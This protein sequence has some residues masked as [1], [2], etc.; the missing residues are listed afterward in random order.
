MV[1]RLAAGLHGFERGLTVEFN[2]YAKKGYRQFVDAQV[3]PDG[4]V[5]NSTLADGKSH[6][7]VVTWHGS[8]LSMQVDGTVVY[9]RI[10]AADFVPESQHMLAFSARTIGLSQAVLIDNIEVEV[11]R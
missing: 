3:L 10:D 9:D 5:A 4:H 8:S 7:V 6:K 2:T 11:E 1:N